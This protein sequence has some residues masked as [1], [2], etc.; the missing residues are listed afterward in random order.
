MRKT[1]T[2]LGVD[3][4]KSVF[5]LH[6]SDAEGRV[7]LHRQQKRSQMLEFFQRLPP[8]LRRRRFPNHADPLHGIQHES[9]I[10]PRVHPRDSTWSY[11]TSRPPAHLGKRVLQD[12]AQRAGVLGGEG[13][14]LVAVDIQHGDDF[15]RAVADRQDQ[16]GPG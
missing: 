16:F 8:C 9:E 2:T 7:V 6:G 13:V 5:Q 4:A 12:R 15:S 1:I 11:S 3:L 10:R 14:G